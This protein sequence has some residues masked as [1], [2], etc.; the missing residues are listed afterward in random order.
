MLRRPLWAAAAAVLATSALAGCGHHGGGH[1]L[2]AGADGRPPMTDAQRAERR[3]RMVERVTQRLQLDAGQQQR[4]RTLLDTLQAQR[5]AVMPDGRAPRDELKGL[6]A[7][8]QFD[9]SAA[10]TLLDGRLSAVRGAGPQVIAAFGDFYDSLRPEQQQQV[11]AFLE[12][13]GHAGWRRH[14]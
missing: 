3:D 8:P 5:Q 1:W 6:I 4:L 11:R 7:G 10:Q 13:G 12:R 14:G 9:R 2:G